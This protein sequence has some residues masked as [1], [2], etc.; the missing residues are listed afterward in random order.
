MDNQK[1][2]LSKI[3]INQTR[4][5]LTIARANARARA[6]QHRDSEERL[7]T[8]R[9]GNL[10][11]ILEHKERVATLSNNTSGSPAVGSLSLGTSSFGSSALGTPTLSSPASGSSGHLSNHK[12]FVQ[13]AAT[14]HH[15]IRHH[16]DYSVEVD[17]GDRG[18]HD[19][20][21][22]YGK[23]SVTIKENVE[24]VDKFVKIV[25]LPH[26]VD[27]I[28]LQCRADYGSVK[29]TAFYKRRHSWIVGRHG[30]L[31]VHDDGSAKVTLKLPKGLQIDNI[32]IH[33]VTKRY[34]V[35][36]DSTIQGEQCYTPSRYTTR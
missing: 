9:R 27:P 35:I 13:E 10:D 34:L 25:S 12:T 14:Y 2:S 31:N 22:I 4:K 19:I 5:N 17:I 15:H 33:T 28:S 32:R 6:I 20:Q 30:I 1:G 3:D 29:I 8:T 36:S 21:I 26:G 16:T 23:N 24:S 7:S 18:P 11:P